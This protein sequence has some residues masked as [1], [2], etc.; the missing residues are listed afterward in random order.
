MADH[1]IQENFL[2]WSL[3]NDPYLSHYWGLNRSMLPYPPKQKTMSVCKAQGVF[4]TSETSKISALWSGDDAYLTSHLCSLARAG[5]GWSG[6]IQGGAF[7]L[8]SSLL[9]RA[10]NS[11]LASPDFESGRAGGRGRIGQGSSGP[12]SC[13][14][15]GNLN[16][17]KLKFWN[18]RFFKP[19]G[20]GGGFLPCSN[21]QPK[22]L[23][24]L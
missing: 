16:I 21:S 7:P 9:Q 4:I 8:T 18:I 13:E 24:E 19:S 10:A 11:S 1:L 22:E 2:F 23:P 6:L 15:G 12:I 5:S 3:H 17:A 20:G 14:G